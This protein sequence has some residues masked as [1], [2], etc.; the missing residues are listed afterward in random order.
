MQLLFID[1]SG[2]PTPVDKT[3]ESPFFV[4]G[5]VIIPVIIPD[6][7]WHSL[8]D[9]LEKV[10][11]EFDVKG[12]IKW[13][14]FFRAKSR[15]SENFIGHLT[16]EKQE[17]LRV[18][19]FD[20]LANCGFATTICVVADTAAAYA[21]PGIGTPDALYERAY[22]L[23]TERFQYYLQSIR[24]NG[25]VVCDHRERKDD[26]R[27]REFHD[28]LLSG[29][30]KSYSTYENLIEGLFIAPSHLSVGIQ[31]ADMVAGA[32]L[33]K[34]KNNDGRFFDRISPTLRRSAQGEVEGYG[35]VWIPARKMTP[36]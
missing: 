10:K 3:A 4:L 9:R 11:S 6:E 32:A 7:S 12:E 15:K 8:K 26:H 2:T 1:E 17:E 21:Q 28:N 5:G 30:H 27:L 16:A 29:R 24:A 14:N 31:F 22:K 36:C 33:R 19:L 35:L 20:I 25:I 34:F 18:R 23:M 13:R